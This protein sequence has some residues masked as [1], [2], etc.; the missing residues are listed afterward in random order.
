MFLSRLELINISD[1][2]EYEPKATAIIGAEPKREWCYYFEKADLASQFQDWEAIINLYGEV[3]I[4]KYQPR[5]GREW[6]PF[7]EGL[8]HLSKW[9]EAAEIS[10][11]VIQDSNDLAPSLCT[12]WERI[13]SNTPDEMAT[14]NWLFLRYSIA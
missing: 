5:D 6:F 8:S 2:N 13:A 3:S 1:Q 9:Q 12:L 7:I 10:S 4:K 11:L 14:S